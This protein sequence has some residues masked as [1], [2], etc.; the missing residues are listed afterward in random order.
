[1]AYKS[2]IFTPL[3]VEYIQYYYSTPALEDQ[4]FLVETVLTGI[5]LP[6]GILFPILS[7]LDVTLLSV[8]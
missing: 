5:H 1:M 6:Y 2:S 8:T 3:N 7:A 4:R